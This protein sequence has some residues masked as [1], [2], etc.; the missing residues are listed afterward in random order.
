M[1]E[2][3]GIYIFCGIK[4][5]DTHQF[6]KVT[7]EGEEREIFTIHYEDSAMVAA[8]VPMKIYHPNKDNLMMHQHVISS[9]MS[10]N[11]TVIPISFGNVFQTKEDV[12]VL[13]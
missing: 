9:V 11:D 7:L 2:K 3:T 6:G 4:S 5:N 12:Q 1:T 8:V 10:Q 13:L